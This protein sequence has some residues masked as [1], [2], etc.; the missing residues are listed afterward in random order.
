MPSLAR[1]LSAIEH[2]VGQNAI[3]ALFEQHAVGFDLVVGTVVCVTD[4]DAVAARGNRFLDCPHH[5]GMEH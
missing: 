1:Q 3:D 5:G 4:D 2:G